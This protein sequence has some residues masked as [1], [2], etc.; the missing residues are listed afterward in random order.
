MSLKSQLYF[1]VIQKTNNQAYKKCK[2]PWKL[3][4]LLFDADSRILIDKALKYVHMIY[5]TIVYYLPMVIH[6]NTPTL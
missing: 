6:F 5:N 2:K 3:S 4:Y 1:Y